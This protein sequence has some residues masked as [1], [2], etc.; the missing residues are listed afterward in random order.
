MNEKMKDMARGDLAEWLYRVY[1]Q[2]EERPFTQ[3]LPT[4]THRRWLAVADAVRAPRAVRV[5]R[6]GRRRLVPMVPTARI[7]LRDS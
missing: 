6:R 2:P 3:A 4:K 1:W 7:R 5:A